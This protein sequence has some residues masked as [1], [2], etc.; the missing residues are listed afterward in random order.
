MALVKA[1]SKRNSPDKDDHEG[2][3][4]GVDQVL[5]IGHTFVMGIR[6]LDVS[7]VECELFEGG[8]DEQ[9]GLVRV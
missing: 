4:A 9:L 2:R 6:M 5:P 1:D 3:S 8:S 7:V